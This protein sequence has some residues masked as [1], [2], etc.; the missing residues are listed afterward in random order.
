MKQSDIQVRLV[1][2]S[3][4]LHFLGRV[5][6]LYDDQ[7]GTVC[8]D[9]FYTT[10]A[11]VICFMLNFTQGAVCSV[12]N[13]RFGQGRGSHFILLYYKIDII[14]N[15]VLSFSGPI[16]LDNV[17]CRPGD[18]ILEDCNHNSWGNTS[19]SH[20]EDVG[21]VCRPSEW[22]RWMQLATCTCH[23]FFCTYKIFV[24]ALSA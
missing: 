4:N 2:P 5:E 15:I 9:L 10:E 6:V 14:I 17:D 7:W 19:C 23:G 1:P 13:A 12:S 18:E 8:D 11:N 21:V 20:R 16:W 22:H 3:P 24:L